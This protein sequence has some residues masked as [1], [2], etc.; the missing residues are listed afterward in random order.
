MS[1]ALHVVC[2]HCDAANRLPLDDGF[3]PLRDTCLPPVNFDNLPVLA[4][5]LVVATS[6]PVKLIE[7]WLK[8]HDVETVIELCRHGTKTPPMIVAVEEGWEHRPDRAVPLPSEHLQ[9]TDASE[10]SSSSAPPPSLPPAPASS[11]S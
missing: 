7:R 8:Q 3:L 5:H 11:S 2:P 9:T 1:D 6:H 4:R 10:G